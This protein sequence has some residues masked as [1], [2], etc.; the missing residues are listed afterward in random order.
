M[1]RLL[2]ALLCALLFVSPVY[3]GTGTITTKDAAGATKTFDV[4]TDGSGNFGAMGGVCDGAALAQCQAVKAASTAPVATDPAAVVTLSQ[5]AGLGA[6][7]TPMQV[8]LANTGAN[9]TAVLVNQPTAGNLN[10]T[11]VGTGT[12]AT[13][14]TLAA[15]TTKVIGTAR[16]L[17]NVGGVLDAIGQNVA[18]PANWL[19]AGCQFQTTP[20]TITATNGSPLQCDNAANLLVNVKNANA[21]GQAVAASSSPVVLASNQSAEAAWG[22]V[23][24]GAAPPTGAQ[25]VGANASGATGGLVA[26]LIT[27]DKHVFKHI[28]SATDTLAVQGVAS[29]TIRVCGWRSRAAGVAT[30]FLE[31]TASANANCSSANTQIAG[32]AT[33]AANTGETILAPF[34]T[35]LANTSGNGLCINSTGTGGVDVDVW[36]NQF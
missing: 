30:W 18:A 16:L 11:V 32:V 29:Q 8:S 27:C 3:A 14:S 24:T 10:A 13:Q 19:Q 35:G 36:Y 20:T 4:I 25:Y 1:T 5:N 33:E 15:E 23:A 26:G 6:A 9:A 34:W 12:F 21:N 2:S 7:A 28:T 17:G 22:Q 31:N